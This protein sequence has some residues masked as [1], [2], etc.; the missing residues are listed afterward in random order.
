M[1]NQN[2]GCSGGSKGHVL[3]AKKKHNRTF[4]V[5]RNVLYLSQC[6]WW[7]YRYIYSS[8]ISYICVCMCGV[9]VYFMQILYLRTVHV[10]IWKFH[11]V[12]KKYWRIGLKWTKTGKKCQNNNNFFKSCSKWEL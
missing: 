1:V 9:Y 2:G 12:K 8:Y 3:T 11:L 4:C 10:T 6:D 7:K 5:D